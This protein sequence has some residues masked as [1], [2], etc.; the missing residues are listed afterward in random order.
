MLPIEGTSCTLIPFYEP[1]GS[2]ID[3]HQDL[4]R[5]LDEPDEKFKDLFLDP[6]ELDITTL[7][8]WP[9]ILQYLYTGVPGYYCIW[10]NKTV[11]PVGFIGSQLFYGTIEKPLVVDM[12][13]WVSD[14]YK[15]VAPLEAALLYLDYLFTDT[16][17]R[18]VQ[19][20]TPNVTHNTKFYERLGFKNE[21]TIRSI[22]MDENG[23]MYNG[24]M[25]GMLRADYFN[26]RSS[27]YKTK[28]QAIQTL[29]KLNK[30]GELLPV[31]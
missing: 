22:R 26:P 18:R 31:N 23:Q 14:K 6:N 3:A 5:R 11:Q 13:I 20:L 16:S 25:F 28:E 2:I 21:G 1:D 9:A 30:R 10:D 29:E 12:G 8:K 17:I 7:G 15:G 4:M 19:S 24:T 27:S